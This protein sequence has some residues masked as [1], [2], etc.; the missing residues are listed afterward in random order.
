MPDRSAFA[1]P[2][3]GQSTTVEFIIHEAL[4]FYGGNPYEY[5]MHHGSHQLA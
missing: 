1:E 4:T 5:S 3:R 2:E